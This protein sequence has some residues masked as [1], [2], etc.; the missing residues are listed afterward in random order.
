MQLFAKGM[1]P[2]SAVLVAASI[3]VP[4]NAA[5]A[6]AAVGHT[7][8]LL[9]ARFSSIFA[10]Q[11]FRSPFDGLERAKS[12]QV[13]LELNRSTQIHPCHVVPLRRL[14]SEAAER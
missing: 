4:I 2:G 6:R 5:S 14:E 8:W 11:D 1:L 10:E 7:P 3:I 9:P 12:A 13:V